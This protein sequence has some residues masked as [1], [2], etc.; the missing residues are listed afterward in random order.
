MSEAFKTL[1]VGFCEIDDK[2]KLINKEI[3]ELKERQKGFSDDIVQYMSENS[4]EVCNAGNYGVLT[5]RKTMHKSS[6]NK[7]SLRDNLRKLLNNNDIMS[8]EKD[9]IAE[10]GADFILNNRDSEERSVLRRSSLK[11]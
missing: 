5:L 6:L 4:L 9:Q 10:N 2:L 3:K 11:K 7:Q 1:V 8:Q